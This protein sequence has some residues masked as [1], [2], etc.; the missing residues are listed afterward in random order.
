[1]LWIYI[2]LTIL[3]AAL[4]ILVATLVSSYWNRVLESNRNVYNA[5]EPHVKNQVPRYIVSGVG[6]Q[7]MNEG[8]IPEDG[9]RNIGDNI[10]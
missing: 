3:T 10:I 8:L 7:L 1:M 2:L 6:R 5:D 9:R 4:V